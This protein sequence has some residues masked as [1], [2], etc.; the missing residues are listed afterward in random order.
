MKKKIH[1]APFSS[2]SEPLPLGSWWKGWHLLWPCKGNDAFSRLQLLCA[3]AYQQV[4]W[5]QNQLGWY[6]QRV[7]F[8]TFL[9]S[10]QNLQIPSHLPRPHNRRNLPLR[11]QNLPDSWNPGEKN[12]GEPGPEPAWT[13]LNLLEPGTFRTQEPNEWTHSEL[14]LSHLLGKIDKRL[15]K[16]KLFASFGLGM[17]M[18]QSNS[19]I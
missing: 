6:P 9:A 17:E 4:F 18:P 3:F 2:V 12:L 15:E 10:W 19:S 7:P 11:S 13:C 16:K 8:K 5:Y 14:H 1:K